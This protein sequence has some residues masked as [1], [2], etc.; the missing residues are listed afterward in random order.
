LNILTKIC[1]VIL[2]VLVLVGCTVFITLATEHQ[3]WKYYYQDMK[4]KADLFSQSA[5]FEKLHSARLREDLQTLKNREGALAKELAAL[6]AEKVASPEALLVAQLKGELETMTT[7][8]TE[9]GLTVKAQTERN[10]LLIAQLDGARKTI[11]SLQAQNRRAAAEITQLRGKVDRSDRVVRGFQRQL[12]D[13]DERIAELEEQVRRGPA[14]AAKTEGQPAPVTQ[15]VSGSITAVQGELASVNIGSAKGLARGAKLFI[16]RDANFVG[17]LRITDVDE[18]AA[19][20]TI[21]DKQLDPVV[22]DK[23][24]NDLMK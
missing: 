11:D 13:R 19:A 14:T 10:K 24:T 1:V 6:K 9:L 12:M 4:T 5:R 16:Y 18:D 21:Q 7:R 2:V 8:V 3:N 15:K 20:G 22:G 23:V 17:Y